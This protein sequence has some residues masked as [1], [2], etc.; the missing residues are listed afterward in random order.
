MLDETLGPEQDKES[1]D[2]TRVGGVVN[3]LLSDGLAT[4]I[5]EATKGNTAAAGAQV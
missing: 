3:E 5:G 2:M 1:T 4:S